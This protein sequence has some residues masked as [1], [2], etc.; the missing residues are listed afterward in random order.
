M[1]AEY[2]DLPTLAAQR[3]PS[4]TALRFEGRR[5]TYQAF[6]QAISRVAAR[7]VQ[8]GIGAGTRTL[9]VLE[10]RPEYLFAQFALARIGAVFVLPNPYWTRAE[11][12]RVIATAGAEAMIYSSRHCDTG[13]TLPIRLSADVISDASADATPAR[14][15]HPAGSPA[16]AE[17]CIPFSSGTT[18]LPKGVVHTVRSLSGGI[19]QLVAHLGLTDTDRL[20]ISLPLCHIFGTSMMGAALSA[21]AEVTLFERFDFDRCLRQIQDDAV[22][23]WPL[24]GAVA[25]R[26]ASLPDLSAARFPGLRYFMWG[27]SAVPAELAAAITSRTGIGFLCSYGMTEAFAVAFNPVGQPAQWRLDSPGFVAAGNEIR[28]GQGG[29][30]EVRGPCVASGYTV[31]VEDD[32]FLAEGWFRTG[33]AGRVDENERLWIL[34]RLKD[35]IKVSG[36]QVAPAEVEAELS[37]HPAVT[38]AAVIGR[39]DEHRG[40]RVVAFVTLSEATSPADLLEFLSKRLATYKIP[41]EIVIVDE[42][43]RTAAGKLQRA[44]LRGDGG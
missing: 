13:T 5:W 22:T 30:I 31:T 24:A 3:W 29:E 43:P 2:G 34:D 21:G 10:S 39:P 44:R 42:L 17:L 33:D 16:D 14:S 7:L 36:F 11:I 18:G 32:P 38:D 1:I 20:Q 28:L 6:D 12:D 41:R 23:V 40:E 15:P 27:G 37:R 35:M 8:S 9:L 4:R 19:G 26:L 25:N